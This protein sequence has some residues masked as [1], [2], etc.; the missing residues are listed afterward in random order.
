M[1]GEPGPQNRR[2]KER[3]IYLNGRAPKGRK[4]FHILVHSL[5]GYNSLSWTRLKPGTGNPIQLFHKDSRVLVLVTASIAFLG[6][7]VGRWMGS[8]AAGT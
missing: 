3:F 2:F 1:H 7:F 8:G 5:S 6:T 4:I